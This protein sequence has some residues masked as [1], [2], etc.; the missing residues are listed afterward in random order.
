MFGLEALIGTLFG[1]KE[2]GQ[3]FFF[4]VRTKMIRIVHI[5]M[6]RSADCRLPDLRRMVNFLAEAESRLGLQVSIWEIGASHL[7]VDVDGV[8]HRSFG[9][10]SDR[11]STRLNSSHVK[12]SYAVFCLKKKT[13][14]T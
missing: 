10:Q 9:I 1:V 5:A 14:V 2:S 13:N 12:I 7:G 8:K 11:K 4:G 3:R 6:N